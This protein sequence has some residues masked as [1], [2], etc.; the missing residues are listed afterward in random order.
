MTGQSDIDAAE[1]VQDQALAWLVRVQ[2]D[3]ATADDWAALADWLEGPPERLAAFEATELAVAGID[4]LAPAIAAGLSAPATNVLPFTRQRPLRISPRWI[5]A[6]AAACVV[7]VAGPVLWQA[8]QGR[9]ITY[10]TA[11]GQTREVT[12]ADGSRIRMDGDSQ[13]TARL[14]WR[15]RRISMASAEATFDV[16]RD[17][18]R[19]FIVQVGDQQVRVV[20]TQFNIRHHDDQVVVTVRRGVVEVRQPAL[21][22]SPVA[23][24]TV[25]DQLRHRVGART[26]EQARV[27]PAIAFAW[28]QGRLICE[29]RPLSEIVADLNR[30]YAR[31]FRLEGDAGARRFSGVLELGDQEVLAR[32]LADYLSLTVERSDQAITLR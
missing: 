6:L 7:L 21:G 3:A 27:D 23:R 1:T 2:S 22:A 18:G 5:G 20:G 29:D 4:D 25:G 13:L 14:G 26:S 17:P 19:P 32:R 10:R 12:L 9:E 30:R 28:T 16:T 8:S 11:P 31:P 24:L 15:A